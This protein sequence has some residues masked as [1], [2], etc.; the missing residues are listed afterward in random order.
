M[1]VTKEF[2]QCWWLILSGFNFIYKTGLLTCDSS[3]ACCGIKLRECMEAACT[4]SDS[5]V[6]IVITAGSWRCSFLWLWVQGTGFETWAHHVTSTP[7][8]PNPPAPSSWNKMTTAHSL[9]TYG[10]GTCLKQAAL[11]P[12]ILLW[13]NSATKCWHEQFNLRQPPPPTPTP[14]KKITGRCW[15]PGSGPASGWREVRSRWICTYCWAATVIERALGR[16]FL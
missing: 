10:I 3:Q 4:M 2:F 12:H 6:S 14:K 15:L 16:L 1:L 7:H 9:F 8:P 13:G 11:I 5:N